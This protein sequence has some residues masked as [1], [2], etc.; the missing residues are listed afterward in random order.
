MSRLSDSDVG[1]LLLRQLQAAVVTVPT[2]E[3]SGTVAKLMDT[4]DHTATATKAYVIGAVLGAPAT[5]AAQITAI[6]DFGAGLG[7]V[8]A[9]KF[10][11]VVV[12]AAVAGWI[13]E[14]LKRRTGNF[15]LLNGVNSPA[16]F[17][18]HFGGARTGNCETYLW[19]NAKTDFTTFNSNHNTKDPRSS[20]CRSDLEAEPKNPADGMH[21]FA[22]TLHLD[23]R[24]FFRTLRHLEL[25]TRHNTPH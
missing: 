21:A 18:L 24:Q 20:S 9:I 19:V 11:G 25:L 2:A 22:E 17:L 14:W 1:A 6:T 15:S 4:A 23:C 3:K 8:G 7:W 16:D 10:V 12:A 13:A 5:L